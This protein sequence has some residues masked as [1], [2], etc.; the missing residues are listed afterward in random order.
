MLSPDQAI[1]F[2]FWEAGCLIWLGA[3]DLGGL[4]YSEFCHLLWGEDLEKLRDYI[5]NK[6]AFIPLDLY[7]DD[8]YRVL[9]KMGELSPQEQEEWVAR[10]RWYVDLSGGQLVVSGVA[11]EVEDAFLE[12]LIA[13]DTSD[14]SNAF[15]CYIEVPPG[16]YQVEIYSFAPGDLSTAWQQI[17][18]DGFF[19]VSPG[20][21]PEALSAYF[22]RTRPDQ[23]PSPWI[24]LE[25]TEDS[26]QKQELYREL[27]DLKY[28]DFTIRLT[29]QLE[30]LPIPEITPEGGVQWEFRKPE[31]CPLGILTTSLM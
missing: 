23:E 9:V 21:E 10:V 19:P 1:T 27:Q 17:V 16:L 28:L 11:D 5:V 4:S 31:R 22:Q 30:V 6:K 20:I 15:Q 7:Q 3:K 13:S 18:G 26:H 14:V 2:S 8:G 25:L 29:R 24:A 12:M